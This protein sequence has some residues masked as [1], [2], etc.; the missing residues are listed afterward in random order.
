MTNPYC[1]Y[2]ASPP[3]ARCATSKAGCECS[4]P[5]FLGAIT[6]ADGLRPWVYLQRLFHTVF[7][8]CQA[9]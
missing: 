2:S 6:F 5:S 3:A 1:N 4:R 7:P 9:N 8:G